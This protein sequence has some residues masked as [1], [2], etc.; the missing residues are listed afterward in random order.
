MKSPDFYYPERKSLNS[1]EKQIENEN[2]G[3]NKQ[4][5]HEWVIKITDLTLKS[6]KTDKD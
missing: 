1:F 4:N 3:V 2:L 5:K 6:M